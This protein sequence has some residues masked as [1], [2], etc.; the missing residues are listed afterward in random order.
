MKIIL[1]A[2]EPD[3][4]S[5]VDPRFGRG[6]YFLSIH[7]TTMDWQAYPNPAIHQAHGAGI[8]AAQWVNDQNAQVLISGDFGPNAARALQATAIE[9]YLFDSAQTAEE[10]IRQYQENKLR[11]Y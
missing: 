5:Q 8:A 11:R 2:Q 3:I 1:T 4:K 7:P 6:K 9:L 10:V